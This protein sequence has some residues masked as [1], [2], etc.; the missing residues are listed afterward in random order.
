MY[1]DLRTIKQIS[2]PFD[3][4]SNSVFA[5]YHAVKVSLHDISIEDNTTPS[6]ILRII[7]KNNNIELKGHILFRGNKNSRKI[8]FIEGIQHLKIFPHSKIE[9]CGNSGIRENLLEFYYDL[10]IST[11]KYDGNVYVGRDQLNANTSIIFQNN[12]VT[13]DGIVR[14]SIMVIDTGI[15]EALRFFCL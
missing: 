4:V 10:S 9:F 12:E 13:G 11:K 3:H 6:T 7:G 14:G 8:V 5:I 2:R 15:P 1:T